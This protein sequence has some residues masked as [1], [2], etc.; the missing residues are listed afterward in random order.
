M[1]TNCK[2]WPTANGTITNSVLSMFAD[3]PG[4][5]SYDNNVITFSNGAV[6]SSFILD[7]FI[8]QCGLTRPTSAPAKLP[9]SALQAYSG[10]VCRRTRR[11]WASLT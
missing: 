11:L 1:S 8:S 10:H 4:E 9:C 6:R 5:V 3:I 7:V 2:A